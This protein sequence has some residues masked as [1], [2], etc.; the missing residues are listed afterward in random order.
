MCSVSHVCVCVSCSVVSNSVNPWTVAHQAPLS[1]GFSRQE[2]WSGLPFPSPGD[3]PNLKGR[4]NQGSNL[5]LLHCRQIIYYLN[6][7][8]SPSRS[9]N[10]PHLQRASLVDWAPTP[11]LQ[12]VSHPYFLW[13]TV[14]LLKT[15]GLFSALDIFRLIV[16]LSVFMLQTQIYHHEMEIRLL[17]WA[18]PMTVS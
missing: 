10:V 14:T 5:G 13:K 9:V 7:Q 15:T 2:H 8:G 3:L 16:T 12:N 18:L 1:M 11:H 17:T 4:T 6:R